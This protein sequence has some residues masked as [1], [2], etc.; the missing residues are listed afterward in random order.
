VIFIE[1]C[2]F[3]VNKTDEGEEKY[4]TWILRDSTWVWPIVVMYLPVC[5]FWALFDMQG[6]RWTLTATQMDGY[7][8]SIKIR[9]T[10]VKFSKS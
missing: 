4:P 10:D 6:S 5:F 3:T 7:W 8:G 1:N 2:I 9:V